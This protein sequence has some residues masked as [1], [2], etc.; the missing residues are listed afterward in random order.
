MRIF[1]AVL[2]AGLAA[3]QPGSPASGI[4]RTAGTDD[5]SGN[6]YVLISTEG[7][8]VGTSASPVPAPRLTAVC[9][10]TPTG[11]LKFELMA[12]LGGVAEIAYYPPWKPKSSSDFPP[13]LDK[14]QVIMEFLG[15][16]KVKPVKRGWESLPPMPG[17]L[18]YQTPGIGSPNMEEFAYYMQYLRS[19]PTLRL[20]VPGQ[21][22]AQ[23]ETSKWQQ[24]LHAEPLCAT[25]GA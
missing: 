4:T 23:W 10:R 16:T 19:L 15:Y 11:K 14:K 12:D 6:S 2:V 5:S 21:G 24:A 3:I 20:T 8:S 17:E 9:T 7:T 13:R 18:R 1:A 22:V 25:S